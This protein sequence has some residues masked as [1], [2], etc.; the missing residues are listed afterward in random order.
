MGFFLESSTAMEKDAK[1][2]PEPGTDIAATGYMTAR[3]SCISATVS[4]GW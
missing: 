4:R 3:E 1:V 2:A